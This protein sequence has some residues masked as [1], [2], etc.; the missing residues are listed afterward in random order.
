MKKIR[1]KGECGVRPI[2]INDDF[3]VTILRRPMLLLKPMFERNN[4]NDGRV[5]ETSA[6]TKD[7]IEPF[8]GGRSSINYCIN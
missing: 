2:G 1:Y 3:V 4:D 5:Y 8:R 6:G 7:R